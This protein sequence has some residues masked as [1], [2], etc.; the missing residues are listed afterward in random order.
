[1]SKNK[2]VKVLTPEQL[3]VLNSSYPVA[4]E[5]SKQS[6]PRFGMLAKDITEESG[7]GKNKKITVVEAAGTFYT[8]K[9]EGE[10]NE[11][12]GK[13][14]WTKTFIEESP[15]V[16][17]AFHRKQLRYYDQGLDKFISSPIYD[18]KEQILPLY[19]DKRVIARGTPAELQA[20]YPKMTVK[21]KP[22][23]NLKEE[24]ILYVLYKGELYQSNLSQSS[25]WSFLDYRRK[26]NPSTVVTQLGSVEET[27]GSNTYSKMTFTSKGLIAPEVA[28]VV[29]ESQTTL[30]S[31]VESDAQYFLD[32]ADKAPEGED[33]FDKDVAE[34]TAPKNF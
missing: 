19:L 11:E 25:K 13:K 20:K 7:T 4:D 1:M 16:V 31:Q 17:I 29:I 32:Q 9:D 33:T 28:E 10:V 30:K 23:S 6:Y 14:V 27:N 2:E 8:E 21:G 12:T 22:G 34:I 24:T 5:S 26:L 3:E 15:E 18:D